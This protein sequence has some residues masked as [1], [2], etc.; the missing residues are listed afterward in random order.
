M[1]LPPP[2]KVDLRSYAAHSDEHSHSF[3]QL[4]LPLAGTLQM[5]IGAH[6]GCVQQGRAAFVPSGTPHS[7]AG[8]GANRSLV[9]DLGDADVTGEFVEHMAA[10]PFATVSPA[11]YRL[12]SYMGLALQEGSARREIVGHWVPLMLDALSARTARPVSRLSALMAM[13][14]THPGQPWTTE[15]MAREACL[16]VSRLHALFRSELDTTPAAWL[17]QVRLERVQE[18]LARTNQPIAQIAVAAGYSD[19]NALTRAMRKTSGITPAAWRRQAKA[20][21]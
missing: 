2:L 4:V 13:V 5:R 3:S 11:A 12:I 21:A 17:T 15:S 10:R 18:W 20:R 1:A 8:R 6:D 7:Q 9:L 16:S 14:E 19:Q